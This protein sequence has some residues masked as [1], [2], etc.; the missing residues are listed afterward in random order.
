[1]L[2]NLDITNPDNFPRGLLWFLKNNPNEQN[3]ENAKAFFDA[4]KFSVFINPNDANDP[5]HQICL[6]TI[7]NAASRIAL[8]SGSANVQVFG[9]NGQK[10]NDNSG[11]SGTLED[12]IKEVG[13]VCEQIYAPDETLGIAIGNAEGSGCKFC[14]RAVFE[15]WR[16][17][18][19]PHNVQNPF[20][21]TSLIPLGAIFAAG[22]AIY[23]CFRFVNKEGSAIGHRKV[24][25]SLW[26]FDEKDWMQASNAEF[27]RIDT[28]SPMWFCG[29]GHLGQAYIWTLGHLPI[30]KEWKLA[31]QITIQDKD[32]TSHSNLSTSLLTS[33]SNIDIPKAQI[34]NDWLQKRNFGKVVM[35]KSFLEPGSKINFGDSHLICGLDN[36]RARRL[37]ALMHPALMI[38]GGIGGKIDDFQSLAMHTLPSDI[39]PRRVW[40]DNDVNF[41]GDMPLSLRTHHESGDNAIRCG[42]E[43]LNNKAVGFPFV[44]V[45]TASVVMAELLRRS[46]KAHHYQRLSMD[47]RDVAERTYQKIST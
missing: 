34:C 37:A 31:N 21:E 38:D 3:A 33:E 41:S 39:D 46:M 18:I 15:G 30:P 6:L 27:D 45:V 9:V 36:P 16:G 20:H 22:L 12:A 28:L 35:V 25:M 32:L 17:G 43:T 14:I 42:I 47:M 7:V 1:M 40:P 26:D 10:R 23:E 13:G 29:L 19:V 11:L 44:G 24:G 8:P 2:E 4:F 5:A